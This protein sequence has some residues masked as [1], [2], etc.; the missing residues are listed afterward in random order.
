MKSLVSYLEC[1]RYI[2]RNNKD[3]GEYICTKFSD[4]DKKIIPFFIKHP[5]VGVKELDFSDW[6]KVAEI[7][8]TKNHL[9]KEGLDLI[10]KIKVGI[11]TGKS[12]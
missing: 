6:C 11:N 5:I 2:A 3:L 8:K 10:I 1:G 4:I 9:T 7:I 12:T